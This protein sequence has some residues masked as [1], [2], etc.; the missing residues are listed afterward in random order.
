M[1]M[2][3]RKEQ[4]MNLDIAATTRRRIAVVGLIG[5]VVVLVLGLVGAPRAADD[6]PR[7]TGSWFGTA[8]ATSAPLPPLKVLITFTSDGNVIEAHRQ[9]LAESPLGP[10]LATPGHGSWAKSGT[11]EFAATLVIIYEGAE[12]HPTASDQVLAREGSLRPTARPRARPAE[13]NARR[14]DSRHERRLDLRRPRDVRGDANR[15]RTAAVTL[16]KEDRCAPC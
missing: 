9:F 16:R 7:L 6:A 11:N 14:R 13:R 8:T 3:T 15:R 1:A 10:L 2:R 5:T 12:N 4:E